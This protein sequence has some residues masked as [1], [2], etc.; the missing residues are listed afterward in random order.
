MIPA[1]TFAKRADWVAI[2]EAAELVDNLC[3]Q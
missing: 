2:G 1:S 3:R